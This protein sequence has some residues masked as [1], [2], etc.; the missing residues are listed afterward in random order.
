MVEIAR[1]LAQHRISGVPVVTDGNRMIGI[2]TQTDLAHRGETGTEKKRK[3][4]LDAFADADTKAREYLKSHG[5]RAS[6]VMSRVIISVSK[7]ASLS[8]VADVL[9]THRIRQVPVMDGGRLVGM[10]SRADL[11]RKLAEASIAAPAV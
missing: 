5:L 10:I 7:D 3:W 1:L 2:V 11:V 6:D 4:W 9:D 8:D